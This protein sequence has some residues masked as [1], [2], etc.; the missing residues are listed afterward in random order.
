MFKKIGDNF[1]TPQ[2]VLTTTSKTVIHTRLGDE[3]STARPAVSTGVP[4]PCR[5]IWLI[6]RQ[7]HLWCEVT[8]PSLSET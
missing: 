5:Q 1:L 2:P 4:K 7:H 8:I 6:L 3:F